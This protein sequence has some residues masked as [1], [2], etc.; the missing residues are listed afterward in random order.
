MSCDGGGEAD[1]SRLVDIFVV[2]VGLVCGRWVAVV[3][4][5]GR[6][7]RGHVR[8]AFG[9]EILPTSDVFLGGHLISNSTSSSTKSPSFLHDLRE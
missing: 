5:K 1:R 7:W 9:G 4:K 8:L 2:Q 3:Q 6:C